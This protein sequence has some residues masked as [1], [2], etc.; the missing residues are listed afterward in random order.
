MLKQTKIAASISG[1]RCNVDLVRERSNAG[2]NVVRVNAA[3]DRRG[4]FDWLIA[5]VREASNRIGLLTDTKGPE[6]RTAINVEDTTE[7][8]DGS[9]AYH[10]AA[11]QKTPDGGVLPENETEAYLSGGKKGTQT[12]FPGTNVVEDALKQAM[13]YVLPNRTCRL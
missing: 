1:L 8:K 6:A 11:L 12:S 7:Y 4:G 10:S 13:E 5:N 3:H 2:M 9:R